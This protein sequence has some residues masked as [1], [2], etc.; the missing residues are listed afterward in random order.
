MGQNDLYILAI[1]FEIL[2]IFVSFWQYIY[3]SFTFAH[4]LNCVNQSIG[5]IFVFVSN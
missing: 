2:H 1:S 5:T 4:E 3:L